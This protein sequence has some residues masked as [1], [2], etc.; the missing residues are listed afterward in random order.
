MLVKKGNK[1]EQEKQKQKYFN[2]L[3]FIYFVSKIFWFNWFFFFFLI[4]MKFKMIFMNI[5]NLKKKM[6]KEKLLSLRSPSCNIKTRLLLLLL[7][8]LLEA[9]TFLIFFILLKNF[10]L[11]QLFISKYLNLGWYFSLLWKVLKT[12]TSIFFVFYSWTIKFQALKAFFL[13]QNVSM[14]LWDDSVI[15]TVILLRE[16]TVFWQFYDAN[17]R[18]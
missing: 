2:K 5:R 11:L 7:L 1:E 6:W 18:L 17:N 3:L 12:S 14:S 4:L 13:S 15:S 16:R 8:F 9:N 10:L